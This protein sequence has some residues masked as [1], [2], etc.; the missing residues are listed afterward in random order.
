M[1][2]YFE[3]TDPT[4]KIIFDWV[5]FTTHDF[6]SVSELLYWLGLDKVQWQDTFGSKGFQK[7]WYFNGISIHYDYGGDR[8]FN[9]DKRLIWVEMSGQGCRT[10]ETYGCND[11][12]MIFDFCLSGYGNITRLDIAYD[13]IE[14]NLLDIKQIAD[15]TEDGFFKSEFQYWEVLRSSKGTSIVHGSP[16]S[17]VRI[18]IYDKAAEKKC[19]PGTH[20]VRVEMQLRDERALGY[21]ALYKQAGES[22]CSVIVNYLMYCKRT[23][24]T[25]KS[26]WVIADYW[27]RFLA[28]AGKTSIYTK[29]GSEYNLQKLDDLV[30]R[31]MRNAL[32]T[33]INIHGA[34]V[35]F[36][37]IKQNPF[38][39]KPNI[40]YT[41]LEYNVRG[42]EEV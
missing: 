32:N 40:K 30:Y 16:Q 24:D 9:R 4:N 35:V 7:R 41:E 31:Q 37:T 5:S 23:K 17:Q 20:W 8:A 18:R 12:K 2:K 11:F 36:D 1:K 6:D 13:D 29:P 33:A 22:F 34:D 19:A 3:I 38:D 15:D 39:V 10:Y 25:N 27:A 26:R 21:L 14:D 28:G 42:F